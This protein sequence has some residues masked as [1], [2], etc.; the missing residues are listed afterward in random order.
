MP[1]S[2]VD[3]PSSSSFESAVAQPEEETFHEDLHDEQREEV[4]DDDDD[5][6]LIG[7]DPE[8]VKVGMASE[9]VPPELT[10]TDE[11]GDIPDA[12][13][14]GPPDDPVSAIESP[15]F[16]TTSQSGWSSSV[17]VTSR[18]SFLG[19]ETFT[20]SLSTHLPHEPLVPAPSSISLTES[21]VPSLSPD[22]PFQLPSPPV[23]TFESVVL[24]SS[25]SS[26]V[27][28]PA[29]EASIYVSPPVQPPVVSDSDP[30]HRQ[31]L[32]HETANPQLSDPIPSS[33]SDALPNE[34][35]LEKES[36]DRLSPIEDVQKWRQEQLEQ[37]RRGS[38]IQPP[39]VTQ[40]PAVPEPVQK[41]R[42]E[43]IDRDNTAPPTFTQ[44]PDQLQD[45]VRT[46][47]QQPTSNENTDDDEEEEE[48]GQDIDSINPK[49]G[50]SFPEGGKEPVSENQ[51]MPSPKDSPHLVPPSDEAVAS[52]RPSDEPASN[53]IPFYEED[54][55]EE[56]EQIL[57]PASIDDSGHEE[58]RLDTTMNNHPSHGG[59]AHQHD[60]E[61]YD[62][63]D[64]V[65][66]DYVYQDESFQDD[67]DEY[68]DG[69]DDIAAGA[70]LLS[71]FSE[72][73]TDTPPS[74]YSATSFTSLDFSSSSTQFP[75]DLTDTPSEQPHTQETRVLS[76]ATTESLHTTLAAPPSDTPSPHPKFP[77]DQ[78]QLLPNSPM[79]ESVAFEGE[80]TR[81]DPQAN[82][83]HP[84][85]H[86]G[87]V[88]TNQDPLSHPREGGEQVTTDNSGQ[89]PIPPAEQLK[90]VP[91]PQ[92]K[93][94]TASHFHLPL[95]SF[96]FEEEGTG[97]CPPCPH[98]YSSLHG[99]TEH[100]AT[101]LP[102]WIGEWLLAQVSLVCLTGQLCVLFTVTCV[103]VSILS[104]P[105]PRRGTRWFGD[106][107]CYAA[108]VHV[109][110]VLLRQEE[111]EPVHK[112]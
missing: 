50:D 104:L 78:N 59:E 43:Q 80:Q 86:D 38:S 12:L 84:Q 94:Y 36:I 54:T 44:S 27:T 98:S 22:A 34:P 48:A 24:V 112:K 4:D 89:F 79:E 92:E 100:V 58:P 87:L 68:D 64:D 111:G 73:H 13:P 106:Y 17:P 11:A 67:P 15:Y 74:E 95:H 93:G 55:D 88:E 57:Y 19:T 96:S 6:D 23:P 83:G 97:E 65:D 75:P 31:R 42:Q 29:E 101:A 32:L 46:R 66:E 26:E 53:T 9:D 14:G 47:Q 76:P 3:I 5:D 70:T 63:G 71:S 40:S 103:L 16:T 25:P 69:D 99:I 10:H 60:E 85:E 18:E 8:N 37:Y 52:T 102:P 90:E 61:D 109:L 35:P 39:P 91:P 108:A 107:P 30:E 81:A 45:H 51:K 56:D 82:V 20:P 49:V 28:P 7:N 77:A 62:D 33:P 110:S 105:G 72:I 21:S 1:N 41:W 2:N